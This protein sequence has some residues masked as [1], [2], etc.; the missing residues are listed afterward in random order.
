M[1][2]NTKE[3]INQVKPALKANAD[4][5]RFY[6][7]FKQDGKIVHGVLD[8]T[9]KEWDKRTR[10]SKAEADLANKREHTSITADAEFNEN[11]TL[12]AVAKAYFTLSCDDTAWNRARRDEYNKYVGELRTEGEL[13]AYKA[14]LKKDSREFYTPAYKLGKKKIKDIKTAHID[15]IKRGMEHKGY[16]KQN[17]DGCSPRTIKKVL[18]QVIKPIL[19]Y[20]VDNDVITKVP[21]ITSP[22]QTS[23][24]KIVT[25]ATDTL[26]ILYKTINSL[27]ADDAFYRALFL[28]ALYGRRLNEILTLEW[29]DINILQN[30]YTI[31][32][33]NSKTIEQTYDLPAVIAEA[34]T[35]ITADKEGLIFVS[36]KTGKKLTPPKKQLLKVKEASGVE[37][38]TMHYFRHILVSAMAENDVVNSVLS[39]SLG[40]ANSATTERHYISANHAR[41]SAE[42]NKAIAGLIS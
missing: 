40:H 37:N 34:L 31:R 30:A 26:A 15:A 2:I 12:D 5:T 28:F 20:A 16:S 14:K 21:A 22:K 24:K 10:T 42:A 41:A 17:A 25:N 33:E 39:A 36:P 38:L 18:A 29:S 23:K 4:Y 3:F 35:A 32:E 19:Q 1:A 9:S 6:F 11:S 13:K 7:R 8:Y 27:Y